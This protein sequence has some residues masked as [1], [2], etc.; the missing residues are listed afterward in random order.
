MGF[1][2]G[3]DAE[4]YDRLYTDR[5]LLKR[6]LTFFSPYKRSIIIVIS[7]LTLTSFATALVPILL[8]EAV[9]ILETSRDPLSLLM[10]L[11]FTLILNLLG[12]VF[13]YFR[14]IHS[15]R[16]IGDVVLDLRRNVDEVVLNHDLSFFDKYPTG[17]IVSRVNTDSRDFGQDWGGISIRTESFKDGSI[18]RC[19][20]NF[21]GERIAS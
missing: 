10:I 18:F 6:V 21:S 8:A 11:I 15:S 17:K 20:D 1:H 16:V 14:Q 3:L 13:N 4:E 7:F 5:E 9:S 19:F 12:W 2:F